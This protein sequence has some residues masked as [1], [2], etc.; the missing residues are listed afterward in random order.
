MKA[1]TPQHFYSPQ[2]FPSWLRRG[3]ATLCSMAVLFALASVA[4]L[5]LSQL[6]SQNAS[7]EAITFDWLQPTDFYD[8]KLA[9]KSDAEI[10][11]DQDLKLALLQRT[12]VNRVKYEKLVDFAAK[13]DDNAQVLKWLFDDFDRLE[14]YLLGGTPEGGEGKYIESLTALSQVY[15]KH[16]ADLADATN[17]PVFQKMMMAISLAYGSPVNGW[18]TADI[19]KYPEHITAERTPSEPVRR[20]EVIKQLLTQPET[21]DNVT[22]HFEND[23]FRDLEIEEMRWVVNNR[24]SDNE[25]PWLN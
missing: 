23:T 2:N 9:G 17:G 11:A 3:F 4:P 16:S 20:Y 5:A 15:A 19:K 18:Q 10:V 8:Q 25:I 21:Y 12:F 6:N 1:T 7:A 13:S 22:T 24:I 14:A